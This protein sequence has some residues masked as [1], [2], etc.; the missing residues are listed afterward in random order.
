MLGKEIVDCHCHFVNQK[1]FELY[2]KTGNATKFLNIRSINNVNLLKPYD[3]DTFK[4][5][6]NMFFT[7]A[8]DL[9]NLA[10]ELER[11][12]E[13]LKNKLMYGTDFFSDDLAFVD[14][15][16][17]IKIIEK[18]ELSEEDKN[19]IL[20]TNVLKAYKKLRY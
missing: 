16:D 14:V 4:N 8:V 2:K 3:F 13:N 11:V 7:E 19:Q 5:E 18:L 9:N 6:H 10:E 17:Y 15:S 1:D 20:C 12:D